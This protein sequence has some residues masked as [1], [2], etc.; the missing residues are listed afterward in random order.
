MFRAAR[1]RVKHAAVYA[2]LRLLML[3][4]R[5]LPRS[6]ALAVGAQG[7]RLAY[8]LDRTRGAL[9]RRQL[10]WALGMR[11]AAAHRLA[12]STY[13]HLGRLVAEV[14]R[15]PLSSSQLN[16]LVVLPPEGEACLR[17]AV[18]EGRGVVF[19]TGH[20]GNWELMAQRIA[21]AGFD[22]VTVVR[23][24]SN[25]YLD[26]WLARIRNQGGLETIERG[27]PSAPRRLLGAL[28]RGAMVGFLIDQRIAVPSV[29]VPFFG[30]RAPT[31]LAAA[32]LAL[33]GE[34]PVVLATVARYGHRH[35]IDVVRIP[36]PP[37]GDRRVRAIQLTEALTAELERR[38]RCRPEQWMWIHQRWTSLSFESERSAWRRRR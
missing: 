8:R 5:G 25:R 16:E 28:R 10:G 36:L 26:R 9:A 14:G 38:I 6:V 27:D 37:P 18:A 30:R 23:E 21:G 32:A 12:R 29:D 2:L 34:R 31:P 24:L 22:S 15:L 11:P 7:G 3:V 33:R 4:V 19:V 13:E 35:H 17:A 1:K 20:L